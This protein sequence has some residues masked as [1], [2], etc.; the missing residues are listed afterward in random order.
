MT[1]LNRG[2]KMM[3]AYLTTSCHEILYWMFFLLEHALRFNRVFWSLVIYI[4]NAF[5]LSYTPSFYKTRSIPTNLLP[6]SAPYLQ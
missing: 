3:A 1:R 2:T 4:Q 6:S 5:E